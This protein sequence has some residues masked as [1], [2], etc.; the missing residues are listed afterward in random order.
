MYNNFDNKLIQKKL[1]YFINIYTEKY[2]EIMYKSNKKVFKK[3]GYP[4]LKGPV[5]VGYF[6]DKYYLFVS[7]KY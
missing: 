7:D 2:C 3:V 4:K 1:A 6:L 5:F